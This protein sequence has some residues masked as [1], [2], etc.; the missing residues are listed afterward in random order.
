MEVK[1]LTPVLAVAEIE[2]SLPLWES[3]GFERTVSVPHG[4]SLGF[5]IL[6]RGGVE[7]MLQSR[8]S[9]AADMPA[10]VERGT[11]PTLVY[12]E[13]DDLDAAVGALPAVDVVVQERTTDYGARETIFRDPDG[14][15]IAL[16]QF[17][18]GGAG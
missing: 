15:V 13:V 11:G 1:K 14:H 16:A 18:Q 17:P 5:V 2:R 4:E 10:A 6:Q 7:V 9:L 3:L 12:V 8:D